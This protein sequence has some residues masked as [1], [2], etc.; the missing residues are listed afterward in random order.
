[1][2]TLDRMTKAELI[3]LLTLEQETRVKRDSENAQL[4]NDV[5]R[6]KADLA[7]LESRR[8]FEGQCYRAALHDDGE[9]RP[10]S[11]KRAALEAAK[12]EAMES[13]RTVRVQF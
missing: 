8:R 4:R 3:A 1:M 2:K 11:P 9:A 13:G 5:T 6:L 12:R 10:I 7:N